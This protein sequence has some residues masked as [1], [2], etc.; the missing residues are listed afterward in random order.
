MRKFDRKDRGKFTYTFWHWV[1][2]QKTALN[3]HCWKPYML[4]HDFNK[5]W[6][7]LIHKGDY[8]KVQF[9]HR[10]H[11]RHHIEYQG[12]RGYDYI[13][14]VIDWECSHLTKA[15]KP[16]LAVDEWKSLVQKKRISSRMSTEI[17][18]VL[19]KLKLLKIR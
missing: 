18:K 17:E 12:K 5:P 19:K 2:F 13:G 16:L 14:M 8:S 7:M 15:D 6:L 10:T 9:Y 4:F 3:L 1:A 11:A